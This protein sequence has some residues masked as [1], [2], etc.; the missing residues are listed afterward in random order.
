MN[1]RQA[2][3]TRDDATRRVMKSLARQ[4][5]SEL[6]RHKDAEGNYPVVVALPYEHVSEV[7]SRVQSVGGS[8]NVA[9]AFVDNFAM[10]VMG[11]GMVADGPIVE[12]NQDLSMGMFLIRVQNNPGRTIRFRFRDVDTDVPMIS[13]DLAYA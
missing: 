7:V 6:P 12:V 5:D 10:M 13:S 8:A 2:T 9:V 11:H 3:L 4:G 1:A